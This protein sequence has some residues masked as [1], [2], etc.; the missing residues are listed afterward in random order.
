MSLNLYFIH[1]V[2]KFISLVV[3]SF[4]WL[5][6][7][8]EYEE[9]TISLKNSNEAKNINVSSMSIKYNTINKYVTNRPAG[10]LF[11][12]TKGSDGYIYVDEE[13]GNSV[14]LSEAVDEVV[15][16]GIG[17]VGEFTGRMTG[18]GPDC[19]GCSKV[20]N[21]SCRTESGES[22]SLIYDGITYNDDEYGELRIL[23][24]TLN[25]F[26]C[27]TIVY[28]DNGILDPFYG[29]V[30]DTGSAMRNAYKEDGT[31]WMDLA[32]SSE[33]VA[34][35]GGATSRNTKYVVQRWGF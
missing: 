12:T 30:L 19:V 9:S 25:V 31:I 20:G 7:S 6:G 18:Y 10:L 21:V 2:F 13:T 17:P 16:V 15:E 34:L 14:V 23:A 29:I 8:D 28:V 26:P 11:T 27:G 24:A 32:F 35:T 4:I 5:F 1:S 3:V 22:H 33:K